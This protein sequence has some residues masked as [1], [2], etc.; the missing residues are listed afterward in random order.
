M[1]YK[2]FN[3]ISTRLASGVASLEGVEWFNAQYD[4]T[5]LK[6]P[7]AFVEFPEPVNIEEASKNLTRTEITVRIHVVSK[8][9]TKIDNMV[10]DQAV[11]DHEAI[12]VAVR[13]LLR[14]YTLTE[15][16]VTVTPATEDDPEVIISVTS[17]IS[18]KLHW[19]RMQH[20]HKF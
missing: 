2:F 19:I 1:L 9:L 17:D 12:A 14:G 18:D 11:I 5:I 16:I 3:A 8:V 6:A 7:V 20:F 10:P 15:T 4:G 13:N